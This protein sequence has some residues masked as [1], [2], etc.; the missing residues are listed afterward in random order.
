MT[1]AASRPPVSVVIPTWNGLERLRRCLE[2][3]DG[4]T[5]PADE[6]IVV[7]NG[8]ADG[9]AAELASRWPQVRVVRLE[10]N[11]G[12]AGGCNRGIE[13]AAAGSDIVLLN[14]DA[15]PRPDW[16][17]LLVG[18]RDTAEAGV[19]VL[20][21]KLI[22]EDGRLESTGDFVTTWGLPFQRGHGEPDLGQYD[23]DLDILAACG[24]AS[25]FRRVLL[26]DVGLLDE[27]FF[28]YYEDVDLSIRARL[29]GWSVRLVPGAMVDHEG[30]G[31]STAIPGFRRYHAARNLWF[32]L[33]KNVPGPLL[34]MILPRVA[35][36]Q[37]YWLLGAAR[38]GQLGV[39]LRGHIDAARQL[40]EILAARRQIQESS[41]TSSQELR[42]LLPRRRAGALSTRPRT[43]SP[44]SHER[45]SL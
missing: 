39:A 8:S 19:G 5:R 38:H 23:D 27:R 20:S 22:R 18:A 31:T 37:A 25:L 16:L 21:S 14:N 42:R 36:V 33:L 43:A 32:L 2:A 12:F 29:A 4:Q 3:L 40:P 15:R 26:A 34:P 10:Q 45:L 6:V 1:S 13:A 7:D 41:R 44:R 24:G 35:A 28:A 9:T 17:Q 11:Q 30:G